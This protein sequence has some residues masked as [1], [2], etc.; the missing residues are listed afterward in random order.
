MTRLIPTFDDSGAGALK[1]AG[2][3]DCVIP[4]GPRFVWERLQSRDELDTLLSSHSA[5]RGALDA[6]RHA[7]HK[8]SRL[9]RTELGK[10]VIVRADDFSSHNLIHR[11]WGG[12]E[13]TNDRLWRWDTEGRTLV[14][15]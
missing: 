3:A 14:A 4:F 13:L 6:D 7:R 12:T 9:T 10:A 1:G 11:W 5:M 8:R 15:P 2:L